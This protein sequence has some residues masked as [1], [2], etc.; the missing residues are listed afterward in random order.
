VMPLHIELFGWKV[1]G[2]QVGYVEV[3]VL[4]NN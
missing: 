1:L 2:G 3:I 4:N